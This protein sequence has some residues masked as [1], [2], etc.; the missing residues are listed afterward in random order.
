M[1]L[2][3]W[4]EIARCNVHGLTDEQYEAVAAK[5]LEMD[6]ASN[7]GSNGK[8]FGIWHAASEVTGTPCHCAK[9][10]KGINR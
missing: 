1:T 6:K 4:L 5:A 10:V 9:C 8:P 3:Y 2:K 7:G